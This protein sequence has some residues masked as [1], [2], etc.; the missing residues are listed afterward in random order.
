MPGLFFFLFIAT[1][2]I[3]VSI[4]SIS[5]RNRDVKSQWCKTKY[6]FCLLKKWHFRYYVLDIFFLGFFH[7]ILHY[8]PVSIPFQDKGL[9]L[10][11]V[12]TFTW[13]G[14]ASDWQSCS[15][16]QVES[17]FDRL[18]FSSKPCWVFPFSPFLLSHCGFLSLSIHP[19]PSNRWT[20]KASRSCWHS[21]HF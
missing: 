6:I 10:R 1:Y 15:L 8:L 19:Q 18:S 11:E 14:T 13:I 17:D 12:K 20:L 2:L 21:D 16:T 3:F 9:G 5:N 4:S 7:L